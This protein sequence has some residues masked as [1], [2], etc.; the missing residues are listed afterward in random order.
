[1]SEAIESTN[2][3]TEGQTFA[4][5]FC[6]PTCSICQGLTPK[7]EPM[8]AEHYPKIELR[9]VDITVDPETAAQNQVFTTPVLLIFV[10]GR[11]SYRWA[12]SFSLYEVQEKLDRVY[13]M[14]FEA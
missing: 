6:S 7:L 9:K 4:Y 1:M 2:G 8:F 10:E 12:H 11:E 3:N 13:G 5:Y 14:L